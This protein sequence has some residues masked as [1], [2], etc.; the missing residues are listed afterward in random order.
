[1]R[2][3]SSPSRSSR[4]AAWTAR[5]TLAAILLLAFGLRVAGLGQQ[6]LRG[7]EAFGHF[8]SQPS[9]SQIVAATLALQEPH[10]VASYFLQHLWLGLAGDS[11]Y[12]LR[13]LSACFG[14][15]AVALIYRLGLQLGLGFRTSALAAALLAVSP[16]AIWH[17]QD[18]RMYSMSLALTL[19]SVIVWLQA[20]QRPRWPVWAAAV[21]LSWLALQTHY[22]AVFVLLALNLAVM[23]LV[24]LRAVTRKTA[25]QW[26]AS[27]LV[28]GL[29]YLP[30]LLLAWDTLAGYRGNGDSPGFAAMVQRALAVFAAGEST[31][32]EWRTALALLGGALVLLGIVRLAQAGSQ[33]R[34]ALLMLG[35]YLGVPLLATW[36]SALQRPIFD[37]RYLVAAAP[38]FY[39]FASAAVFGYGRTAGQPAAR[40]PPG[41]ARLMGWLGAALL[42]LLLLGVQG[43]LARHYHDPATSK[44]RGWRELAATLARFSAGWPADQVRLAQNF[45]DPTLWYY[46]DG[47]VQHLM[48]PPAA[49]DQAG[50]DRDTTALAAQ[51]VQRVIIPLQPAGWWDD[52]GI[53]RQALSQ[54]YDLALE[55]TAGV[56]PV[57]VYQL[58]PEAV[59][60]LDVAFRNG[61]RLI[62]ATAMTPPVLPGDVLMV[63]LR[64]DGAGAA[65]DGAEKLTLQLLDRN[66]RV[67]AQND[68]AFGAA[69][70]A[71]MA[72]PYSVPLPDDLPP[73]SYRLIAALYNPDLAGAPRLLT[74]AG[75]DHVEL[76]VVD[77]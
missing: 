13:F 38:P 22:F 35:F 57:Q 63:Y 21:A 36:L 6:E 7:D 30:W 3:G 41:P 9:L 56:W 68:L 20:L 1:M 54:H 28:L 10:P 69:D 45:P 19:A 51:G 50:A 27:Q 4:N 15:A 26:L 44:T 77:H 60:P 59:S 24:L 55:T 58:P 37:E 32:A 65:L 71:A 46:Y 61:L 42:V 40:I 29:A 47:P 52:A 75:A 5:A 12:A 25:L 16:Y 8:F 49:H 34:P 48:L 62:G 39:L 72:R 67:A 66:G 23:S 2:S 73:G 43:S 74:T 17:S 11:E 33:A 18:A 31:P 64:W 14:V 76:G 53:A 70:L